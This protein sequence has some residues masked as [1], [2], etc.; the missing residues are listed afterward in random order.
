[1]LINTRNAN[2]LTG[3]DGYNS[4]KK[5]SFNLAK[6]LTKKQISDEDLPKQIKPNHILFA[7]TGTIGERYPLEQVK[8]AIPNLIENMIVAP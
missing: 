6:L 3:A 8:H 1:M 4:L 7:C 2:A 5:I